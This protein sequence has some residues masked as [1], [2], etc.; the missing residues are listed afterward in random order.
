MRDRNERFARLMD[1]VEEQGG[2]LLP[3]LCTPTTLRYNA[4]V[5]GVKI[6]GAS[7]R[8]TGCNMERRFLVQSL[9]DKDPD[10]TVA[11]MVDD[12]MDLWPRFADAIYGEGA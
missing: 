3:G 1:A 2:E 7:A 9:D 12:R 4:G 8:T 6:T 10:M 11:C 5:E